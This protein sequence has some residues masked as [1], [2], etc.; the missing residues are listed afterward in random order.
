MEIVILASLVILYILFGM[1]L[2]AV[3]VYKLFCDTWGPMLWLF[4]P[5]LLVI[6][7]SIGLMALFNYG[8][9]KIVKW[10]RKKV[11]KK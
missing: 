7:P 1:F 9:E 5:L 6:L 10:I 2:D 8:G 3:V 11:F 4:W